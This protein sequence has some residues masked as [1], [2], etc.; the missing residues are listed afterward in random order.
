MDITAITAAYNGL[1]FI[2]DS[3][4][5]TLGYKIENESREQINAALKQV[6]TIQDTLFKI[7]GDMF[8]LQT[9]NEELRKQLK[10]KEGWEIQKNQYRLEQTVRG[11]TVFAF[12]GMPKYYACPSCFNKE[13]IEILQNKH[14]TFGNF[15]CPGC[16]TIYPIGPP[17]R[18]NL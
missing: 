17:V 9:E 1:K 3:L 2:K 15:Y 11:A 8:Q 6:W 7:Q 5:V 10:V 16:K 4:D 14:D 18:I 13:K 12:T